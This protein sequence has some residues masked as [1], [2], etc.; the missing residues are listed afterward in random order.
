MAMAPYV[1]VLAKNSQEG[2]VYVRRAKLPRGRWR[3]AASAGSIRGL[4]KAQV[5]VLPS[6]NDRPDRHSILAELRYA[7]CDFIDVEMPARPV[8]PAKD[9]GDGMG[10]QLTIDDVLRD[11]RHLLLDEGPGALAAWEAEGGNGKTRAASSDDDI[12]EKSPVKDI[13]EKADVPRA[14]EKPVSRK[15]PKAK[16]APATTDTAFDI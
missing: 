11:R 2:A 4:R 12:A 7:K 16:P 14:A 15:R 1:I 5:H 10:E 9:Q 3:I 6:F 13:P 8:Y